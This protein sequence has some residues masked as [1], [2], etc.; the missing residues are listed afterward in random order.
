MGEWI[1]V[2]NKLPAV[3]HELVLVFDGNYVDVARSTVDSFECWGQDSFESMNWIE[4]KNVTH[5]MPLPKPPKE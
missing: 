3:Y 5:W 4:V 1:S 2:K